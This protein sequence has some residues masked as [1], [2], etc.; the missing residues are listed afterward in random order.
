MIVGQP[1]F[2]DRVEDALGGLVGASREKRREMQAGRG[3]AGEDGGAGRGTDGKGAIG[4]G[5]AGSLGGQ[6]IQVGRAMVGPAVGPQV[7]DAEV[8][9]QDEDDIRWACLGGG[10]MGGEQSESET[11]EAAEPE[12][13]AQESRR[14]GRGGESGVGTG[15]GNGHFFRHSGPDWAWVRA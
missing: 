4:A 3:E 1:G 13:R 12:E 11:E 14:A 9:G 8:V 7:V 10:R 15:R 5:E 2:D 6:A